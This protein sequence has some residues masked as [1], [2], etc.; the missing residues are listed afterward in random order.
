MYL[1]DA[2]AG[3]KVGGE[4]DQDG[5]RAAYGRIAPWE[6]GAPPLF[7]F[8]VDC[9]QCFFFFFFFFNPPFHCPLT[10][11]GYA[12][13][14][15]WLRPNTKTRKVLRKALFMAM[16][17]V[18]WSSI[19]LYYIYACVYSS[20]PLFFLSHFSLFSFRLTVKTTA[21]AVRRIRDDVCAIHESTEGIDT[22][23][24]SHLDSEHGHEGLE[25][26]KMVATRAVKTVTSVSSVL[27]MQ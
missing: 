11:S 17:I 24:D 14:L 7:I 22:I 27:W 12:W 8:L 6:L 10:H 21:E 1:V 25:G 9:F 20:T 19:S 13:I 2:A 23:G 3:W 5:D 4:C 16:M 26:V 15:Q 18:S